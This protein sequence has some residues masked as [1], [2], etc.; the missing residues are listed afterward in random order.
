MAL[1]LILLLSLSFGRNQAADFAVE[2]DAPTL[3]RWVYPFGDFDGHRPVANTWG[4]FDPRFDTR[5]G[6][7]LLGWDTT[8]RIPSGAGVSNY[9]LRSLRVTLTVAVGD[10]FS[11]DPT[12]D[13]FVTYMTNRPDARPDGDIGRPIELYGVGYRDGQTAES[14]LE[15]SPFGVIGPIAGTNIAIGTRR[16]FAAMFDDTGALVDV[17]NNVGQPLYEPFEA[18]PWA[19]GTTTN[20]PPGTPVPQGASFAFDLPMAHP[21]IANYLAQALDS[22]RLRLIV[23]SLHA[24]EQLGF[25]GGGAYPQWYTRETLLG[26]AP[27]LELTGNLLGTDDSEPDGLPD[28]WERFHFG[29][30]AA[31]PGDDPDLD[32]A[33]NAAELAAGTDPTDPRSVFRILDF[34]PAASAPVTLDFSIA[35]LRTYGVE[36]SEDLRTWTPL[37][38]IIAY[39]QPDRARWTSSSPVP[40]NQRFLRVVAARR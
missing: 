36:S 14:F 25:G 27:R 6:Q 9:L 28:D 16:V 5:D 37:E 32:G 8:N 24:A 19:I 40:G 12:Y 33:D 13:S 21:L 22:G 29:D 20:V 3:D 39:P 1:A 31:T 30:L 10:K 2:F 17:S 15:G 23:S 38:G 35:A 26:A 7:F 4:S 11:Y 34:T 18:R